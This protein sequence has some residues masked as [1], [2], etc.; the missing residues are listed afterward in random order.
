MNAIHANPRLGI[1]YKLVSVLGFTVMAAM[2]KFA[3]DTVPV[4]QVC[5]FR[6]FFALLTIVAVMAWRREL[7]LALYTSNPIG[8][9]WRGLLALGAMVCNFTAIALL[10]LPDAIALGYAMPLFVT[11]FAAVLL[12]EVVRSFRWTAVAVGLAGVLIILWP[13]LALGSGSAD[14]ASQAWGAFAA[15]G[16]AVVVALGAIVASRL[17]AAERTPTI[18]FY[19]SAICS[20][21]FGLTLPFWWVTPDALTFA[22]LILAGMLGG[23]SQLF[24]TES[25][26]WAATSTLAPFEYTSMLFSIVLALA[27]FGEVPT[28]TMLLGAA[29]VIAA[30]LIVIWREHQLRIARAPAVSLAEAT[31]PFGVIGVDGHEV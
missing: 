11:I 30:S 8:H 7:P 17:V 19:F 21:G 6:S 13:R 28:W 12:G 3:A 23:I 16:G 31:W 5:F 2:I 14:A 26:R 18:V 4:T 10:P 29:V 24:V 15:V 20:L 22:L 27:V 9:L 25:Y 1:F